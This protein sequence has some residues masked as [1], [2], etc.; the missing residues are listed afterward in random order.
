MLLCSTHGPSSRIDLTTSVVTLRCFSKKIKTIFN[1]DRHDEW[2]LPEVH[3]Y[4][5]VASTK[6]QADYSATP[7]AAHNK[8]PAG[9]SKVS[10]CY[11]PAIIMQN[12]N[13]IAKLP[14]A[15]FHS[16]N[17]CFG[18]CHCFRRDR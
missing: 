12:K 1:H 11:T 15:C 17:A 5:R 13:E 14:H 9:E 18:V 8:Q 7:T 10:T 16:E 3:K 4:L 6:R 2:L